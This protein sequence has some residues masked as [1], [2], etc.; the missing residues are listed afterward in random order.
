MTTAKDIAPLTDKE[1]SDLKNNIAIARFRMTET[2]PFFGLLSAELKII[3]APVSLQGLIRTA[4]VT[5]TGVC[6]YNPHFM[7]K[8]SLEEISGVLAHEALHPA[9]DFWG[10]FEH[11]NLQIANKAHDYAINMLIDDN[12]TSGLALPK[13]CL[14]KS[15][16]RNLSAEEI[17]MILQKEEQ[18]KGQSNEK[19]DSQDKGE[20]QGDNQGD[21]QDDSEGQGND[22]ELQGDINKDIV[23]KVEEHYYGEGKKGTPPSK[24]ELKER[25]AQAQQRWKDALEQAVIADQRDGKGVCPAWMRKD[26]DGILYP[27][28]NIAQLLKRYFGQFG[29]PLQPSYKHRNRRN[30]FSGDTFIKPALVRNK[31]QLYVLLDTSGSMW[32]KEGF[33]MVQGT[34]GII[35]RLAVNGG[36]GVRVIMCDTTVT[37]DMDFAEV[38]K[39][40]QK[41]SLTSM[42][43]GGSNFN[44]AFEYI[45]Q[46]AIKTN[47][48]QA[49]ILCIT[50]GYINVPAKEPRIRT[51]TAWVTPQGV[52][53]PTK[54]WGKHMEMMF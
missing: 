12:K 38:I 7:H 21:S 5:P 49:P 30:N 33:E 32:D 25:Q 10:R 15:E 26:I 41:K 42:G 47:N 1:Q 34:L 29:N 35:K 3:P 18:D 16:Y 27:K 44:E 6:M 50:D 48:S 20:G 9:L 45:W 43:G 17:L 31:P 53:P 22:Y 40:V 46:D 54:S 23:E 8:L 19:G 4:A 39:A 51:N 52:N 36:Y 11:V 14:L 13:G 28:M 24:E 37:E 2:T